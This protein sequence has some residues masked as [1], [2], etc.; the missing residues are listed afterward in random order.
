MKHK[1]KTLNIQS[2]GIV[3]QGIQ[4]RSEKLKP[5]YNSKKLY[6]SFPPSQPSIAFFSRK[7][8]PAYFFFTP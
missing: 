1:S 8:P 3:V 5:D 4:K 2:Q 6:F 7:K